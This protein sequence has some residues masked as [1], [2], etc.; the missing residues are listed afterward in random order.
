[1][2]SKE[3]AFLSAVETAK[4]IKANELSPT[5]A[6]QAYLDAVEAG[7]RESTSDLR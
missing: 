5:D 1:M 6:V 3:I 7:D 4:A 2:D